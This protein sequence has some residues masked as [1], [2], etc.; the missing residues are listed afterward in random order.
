MTC[1][2]SRASTLA[3][4]SSSG[5]PDCVAHLQHARERTVAVQDRAVAVGDVDLLDDLSGN[6]RR[7]EV[8]VFGGVEGNPVDEEQDLSRAQTPEV[9]PRAALAT[10]THHQRGLVNER[11]VE[12]AGALLLDVLLGGLPDRGHLLH[13]IAFRRYV[14]VVDRDLARRCLRGR[15]R[16]RP[17][18]DCEARERGDESQGYGDGESV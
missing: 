8:P 2:P 4:T 15:G 3:R 13:Q 5:S 11:L 16:L 7:V 14:D 1:A 18:S 12:V 6:Q 10:A 9:D 17:D